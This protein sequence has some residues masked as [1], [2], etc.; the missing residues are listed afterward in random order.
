MATQI[1]KATR[2]DAAEPLASVPLWINGQRTVVAQLAQ[3]QR[4][5]RRDRQGRSARCRSPNADGRRCGR[6]GGRRGV[7][8]VAGDA[9]AAPRAHPD[10]V[11]RADGAA[12][13]GARRDRQRGARQGV[14]RRDGVGAARHRGGR[15]RRRRAAPAQGRARRIGRPRRR[16]A[17][18]AAAARRLRRHHAVQLPGDGAAVDVPDRAGLRQHVRAEAVGE[19]SVGRASGWRSCC[20]EAGLPDGVFN[21]VHGDKEAV[22]AI[23]HHPDIK[24]VSFVGSTP[25][26]KYIYSTAAANGKRVQALGGAKNHAVVLPDAD[27]EFTADALIG[28]AYGSAGERCMAISAVVAVGAA[29]DPLVAK[30][31][32][33][34]KKLK[35]GPSMSEGM[36][37][38]PL[39][40][41]AHRDKVRGLRRCRRRGGRDAGRRRPRAEGRRAPRA[42]SSSGRRSSTTSRRR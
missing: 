17:L 14:P 33:K 37:M 21:V 1:D 28:A 36:D 38:G 16:R 24:A 18:A 2:S 35:V 23:L 9:A 20:S 5:Q 6:E 31:A 7:S 32:E 8:G 4:D 39:V 26:A 19:R 12:P 42:G 27:L 3:R 40:T 15:V 11:P 25:I 41:E 30:L 29:G 34:A 10:A 22:D 13:E